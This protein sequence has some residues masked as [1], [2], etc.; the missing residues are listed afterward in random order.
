MSR[1]AWNGLLLISAMGSKAEGK[2]GNKFVPDMMYNTEQAK[3]I[4]FIIF[5]SIFIGV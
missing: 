4:H 3:S 1:L 2:P 5:F